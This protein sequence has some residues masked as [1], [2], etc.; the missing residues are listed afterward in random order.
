MKKKQTKKTKKVVAVVP[1]RVVCTGKRL[2]DVTRELKVY[3]EK[4]HRSTVTVDTRFKSLSDSELPAGL[5]HFSNQ[6]IGA[7]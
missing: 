6:Q 5:C 3:D 7:I 2:F 1:Y 4:K